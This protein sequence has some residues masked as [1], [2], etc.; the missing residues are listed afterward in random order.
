MTV[1]SLYP[2]ATADPDPLRDVRSGEW[3][4]AQTFPPLRYAVPGVVSEGYTILA[5]PPKVGKSWLGLDLCLAVASGDRALGVLPTEPGPVFYLALEDGHR[6][7]QDRIRQ[8]RPGQPIPSRFNYVTTCE[9]GAVLRLIDAW[10]EQNAQTRLVVLDT[11]GRVMPPARQGETTY[12]RDYRVGAAI[13]ARADAYPGL[14]V[15]VVHHSRKG[16]SD[17]FVEASSGTFGMAGA[18]DTVAILQ[19]DRLS[20]DAI[21]S[22]TGRDIIESEYGLCR[23]DSGSWHLAGESLAAA[24]TAA[25][26][27]RQ[28]ATLDRQG[29]R[30]REAVT[31]VNARP[32]TTPRDV[33]AHL[34][35]DTK[36]AS[37]MLAR[38]VDRGLIDK[39]GRG[40][41]VP[42]GVP[43]GGSESDELMNSDPDAFTIPSLSSPPS[44][45]YLRDPEEPTDD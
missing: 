5:G 39:A 33:A 29:D 12:S 31:F 8:L 21:L 27:I 41:Y 44:S 22:V 28:A 16:A 35:I 20:P 24:R 17:D 1:T 26:E 19:R 11:L 36:T 6:R 23:V 13:K 43:A 3:L 9:P 18:A 37:N 7:L 30:T 34:G 32:A 14:A 45:D 15:V 40:Q 2:E 38:A 10:L 4:D 42:L 25:S